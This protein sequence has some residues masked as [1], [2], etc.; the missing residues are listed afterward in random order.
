MRQDF[1][2]L[3]CMVCRV[4]QT[5]STWLHCEAAL[6]PDSSLRSFRRLGSLRTV[7]GSKQTYRQHVVTLHVP[8]LFIFTFVVKLA[9]E[10]EG[11][12]SVEIHHHSE[13]SHSQHQLKHNTNNTHKLTAPET[14]LC[15]THSCNEPHIHHNDH[16]VLRM[17]HRTHTLKIVDLAWN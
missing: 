3:S 11:H 17:V 15:L 10:V 16:T 9:E 5:L 1:F 2:L 14:L 12:H 8:K 6:N 13:E 4:C 7:T